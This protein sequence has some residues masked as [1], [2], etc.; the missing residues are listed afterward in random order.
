MDKFEFVRGAKCD[1]ASP[2]ISLKEPTE[3]LAMGYWF[4]L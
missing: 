1:P 2:Y 4:I 3:N